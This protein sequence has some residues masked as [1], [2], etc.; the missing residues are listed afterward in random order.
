M[1]LT[2]DVLLHAE[3]Y[4]NAYRD[5]E[6]N[7]R[8]F[9]I[10]VVENIS[11]LQDTFDVIDF[12]DNEIKKLDNFPFMTRLNAIIMNNNYVVRVANN[13]GDYL[14]NLTTLILT[15][16]R[17]VNLSE[18]VSIASLKKLEVLSLV[19]NS[20]ILKTNYRLYAI[21]KIPTLKWL[22]FR[23]VTRTERDESAKYFKSSQGKQFLASIEHELQQIA[24][25]GAAPPPK[26]LEL[27]L[28]DAQKRQVKQAIDAAKTTA[29]VD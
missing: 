14:P 21:Y 29:E 11:V 25:T 17:I 24:E 2:A 15:N 22:D 19:E 8:G 9:K 1:R 28:T 7:L 6:L 23:K 13:I 10:P 16:N 26:Q 5:R 4:L 18:L 12:S 20:V 27:E 3:H